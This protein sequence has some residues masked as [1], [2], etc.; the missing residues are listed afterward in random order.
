MTAPQT[1]AAL[2]RAHLALSVPLVAALGLQLLDPAH[3]EAGVRLPVSGLTGNGAGSAHAS[4]LVGA[5]ELAAY[6]ALA[7]SLTADEHA[8]PSVVSLQLVAAAP[9]GMWVEATADLDRRDPRT[10]ALSAVARLGD[11]VVARAQITM[12]VVPWS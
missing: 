5:L 4:A 1:T 12:S 9:A 6:L 11:D 10:A 2:D 8:V 3:P 7:P